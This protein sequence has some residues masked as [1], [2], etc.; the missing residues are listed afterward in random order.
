MRSDEQGAERQPLTRGVVAAL[1]RKRQSM[2]D[3]EEELKGAG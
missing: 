3:L 2:I 1:P